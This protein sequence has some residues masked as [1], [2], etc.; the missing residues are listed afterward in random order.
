MKLLLDSN[1]VVPLTRGEIDRLSAKIRALLAN[2]ANEFI[3]SVA[4]LWEIAVKTRIGKLAAD[5]ALADL[6][7]YLAGLGYSLLHVDEHHALA[8]LLDD[9][10]TRDPFDRLLLAQCQVEGL[11]LVTIDRVLLGH[12]LAWRES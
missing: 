9:P 7:A 6:P 12:P 4:S 8:E 10:P 2:E 11:H 1:I 5:I 3:V